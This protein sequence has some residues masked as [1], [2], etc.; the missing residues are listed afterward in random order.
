MAHEEGKW[1][2]TGGM[3]SPI[4]RSE[5]MKEVYNIVNIRKLEQQID[6]TYNWDPHLTDL[7]T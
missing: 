7:F 4:A 2:V 5:I 1:G 3:I 6:S